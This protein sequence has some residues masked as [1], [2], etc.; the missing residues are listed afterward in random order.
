MWHVHG[1]RDGV[2]GIESFE[3]VLGMQGLDCL[4]HTG[5]VLE[6]HLYSEQVNAPGVLAVEQ[7]HAL[8]HDVQ[9]SDDGVVGDCGTSARKHVP[10]NLV[11]VAA[12]LAG[13]LTQLVHLK[14]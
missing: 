8:L 12:A 14:T 7:L 11:A 5:V 9:G 1:E 4:N 10:E 3:A 2:G 6:L 13:L